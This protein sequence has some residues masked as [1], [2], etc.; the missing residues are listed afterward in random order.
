M[1]VVAHLALLLVAV[2]GCEQRD[3]LTVADPDRGVF[4][5]DVFP[6]LARDC[7]FPECHGH[8]DRFMRIYSPGRARAEGVALSADLTSEEADLNFDRARS[9]IAFDRDS[10]LML[11]KPL[12]TSAGGK[13]HEGV[14]AFGRDIF[15]STDDPR[16]RILRDWVRDAL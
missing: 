12:S 3:G 7:S 16:Y 14:D 1:K 4:D 10:S 11:M 2:F 15:R 9:M 8:P 5:D 13:H 6:I